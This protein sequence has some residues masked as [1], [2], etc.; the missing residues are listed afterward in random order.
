V[1]IPLETYNFA[2]REVAYKLTDYLEGAPTERDMHH[3]DASVYRIPAGVP[4]AEGAA[5]LSSDQAT[6]KPTGIESEEAISCAEPMA[7]EAPTVQ[8]ENVGKESTPPP[9]TSMHE[10]NSQAQAE[11]PIINIEQLDGGA[12]KDVEPAETASTTENPTVSKSRSRGKKEH[13]KSKAKHSEAPV[14]KRQHKVVTI[15][16]S[17]RPSRAHKNS[18]PQK[19]IV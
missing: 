14:K 9:L 19:Q 4:S 12:S 18:T 10:E 2:I 1:S 11:V 17:T 8:T 7:D 16:A 5:V 13:G 3:G 6:E 15:S